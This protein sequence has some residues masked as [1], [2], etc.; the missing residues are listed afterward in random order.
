M[1]RLFEFEGFDDENPQPQ[2]LKVS[3]LLPANW[4]ERDAEWKMH[5]VH[6][7][8]RVTADGSVMFDSIAYHN[9]SGYKWSKET[10]W[11]SVTDEKGD[12]MYLKGT[13]SV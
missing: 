8:L 7:G 12:K 4:Q 1:L 6:P 10:I 11:F 13:F 5:S 2:V 3:N 9:Q